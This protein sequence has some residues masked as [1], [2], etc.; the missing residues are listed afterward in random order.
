MLRSFSG[1]NC[2][3]T[4]WQGFPTMLRTFVL[5]CATCN[6]WWFETNRTGPTTPPSWWD[7]VGEAFPR[8]RST[9]G[10]WR[11]WGFDRWESAREI[12][13]GWDPTKWEYGQW[14]VIDTVV[15][16]GGWLIFG[17][18]WNGVRTGCRRVA[19]VGMLLGLCLAAHYVWAVCYPVVSIL[20][21]VIMALV[22]VL[23]RTLKVVGTIFFHAQKLVG[24]APEAADVTF[25]GL[26][27]GAVP[28]HRRVWIGRR[29]AEHPHPWSLCPCGA[30]HQSWRSTTCRTVEAVR[31]GTLVPQRRMH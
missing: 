31:Q 29:V 7:Q 22:W 1:P 30:G 11:G 8:S 28:E 5:L 2:Q 6:G 21:G 4:G 27:T 19:Q 24:M 14:M 9:C 3:R 17:L 20:V 15:S 18:S 13:R 12:A 26:G 16:F 10:G 23:R 25:I